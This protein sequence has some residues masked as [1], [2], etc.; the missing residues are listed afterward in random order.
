MKNFSHYIILLALLL[1]PYILS[2]QESE[3]GNVIVNKNDLKISVGARVSMD[4]AVY[5]QDYTPLNSGASISD[6][7]IR[8]SIVQGKW[9]AYYDVDFGKGI[10]TQKNAYVRYN[11]SDKN[12]L[13][14]GYG[15][16]PFSISYNTSQSDIHFISRSTP[17]NALAPGR[18]LGITYKHAGDL[19][20]AEGGIY[21][22]NLF[23]NQHEGDQGYSATGRFLYRAVQRE[24]LNIHFGLMGRY[25]KIGTGYVEGNPEI[26]VR[27]MH[28][29]AALETTVDKSV[30]FV[31]T[32]VKWASEEMKY[33]L[34]FLAVGK[35]FFAQGEFIGSHIVRDRPDELL[36]ENQLGGYWSWTTLKSWL[37][38]NPTLTDLDFYGG[39]VE[40]GYLLKGTSYRYDRN[41]A[42]L[43]RLRDNH[44]IELVGRYSM[45]SM[46]DIADGDFFWKGQNRFFPEST[47]I[48]DYPPAS[49]SIAGGIVQT[50]TLGAN[51]DFTPS[52]RLMLHYTHT[53]IDNYY[54]EDDN[55][56]MLQMRL[57][58]RF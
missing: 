21:S 37:A 44:A 55:V 26:F 5:L 18:A 47:G 46:N 14:L 20:F 9:D 4:G 19:F 51:Y 36:F 56:G 57:Q 40:L 30:E 16:E 52:T 42:L 29:G 7:R 11:F 6:A 32:D 34:E 31:G 43:G 48:T 17:V 49:T 38:G 3:T 53:L 10:L 45:T 13:R 54:F 24:D 12:S 15:P 58:Y 1:S 33:G 25:K 39:Y 28:M 35:K 41:N 23:N 8:V 50:I 2:A 22:E 27:N